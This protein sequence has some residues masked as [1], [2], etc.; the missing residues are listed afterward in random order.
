MQGTNYRVLANNLKLIFHGSLTSSVFEFAYDAIILV[1][2]HPAIT[3]VSKGFTDLFGLTKKDVLN[4]S[5][6]DLFPTRKNAAKNG[7]LQLQHLH[8]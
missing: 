5:T 1:N 7:R 6:T 2:K 8:Q 3:M 4:K